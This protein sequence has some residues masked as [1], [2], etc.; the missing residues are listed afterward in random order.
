MTTPASSDSNQHLDEVITAYLKAVESGPAPDQQAWLA[1]YPELASELAAFFAAQ[2]Q[3]EQLAMPLRPDEAATLAPSGT[4]ASPLLGKVR[5]FGD[6]ELLEEIAR[7]GMGVVYKAR[8]VSLNRIVALKM[9]LA[10]QFAS[11][12]DVERFHRE[13]EAAAN[14]DHPNIVP[15]YEVGEHD[16]QHYF[17]MKLIEGGSLASRPLPMP[18]REAAE[19][20]AT[21]ARAVHHAHQRGILHRDLKPGNILI[22]LDDQPYVTD[23]GLAKRVEGEPRHTRTGSIVGTPSYMAPEQAR[24]EKVL[25]TAV[26]VYS[27]GAVFY[28]LLT[29]RPPFR[30]ETPLDTVLQVLDREPERPR[31]LNARIDADLET[32]CLKCLEK[33]SGKRY[34]SAEALAEE[35][36]RWLRGEPILARPVG[37]GERVWRWCRR[38]RGLAA[39]VTGFVLALVGGTVV[40]SLLAIAAQ[41]NAREAKD[42]AGRADREAANALEKEQE[43][44]ENARIAV[45]E[46]NEAALQRDEAR[47]N[48]YVLGINL[49][50]RAWDE[51]PVERARQLL[52]ELSTGSSGNELRG[53]EWNYLSRLTRSCKTLAGHSNDVLDVS[54]NPDGARLATAGAD[55]VIKTWST[56]SGKEVFSFPPQ[57]TA[58]WKVAFSSDGRHLL[59]VTTAADAT[60]G[61]VKA[62][63]VATGA[64]L[65]AAKSPTWEVA[66]SPEGEHFASATVDGVTVWNLST[67]KEFRSHKRPPVDAATRVTFS[68][69]GQLLAFSGSDQ[70]LNVWDLATD[71]ILFTL[72]AAGDWRACLAFSP[73]GR[74]LAC[75]KARQVTIWAAASGREVCSIPGYPDR[76]D[77]LALSPDG[78][79]ILSGCHDGSIHVND[80][81]SGKPL[82]SLK[83]HS[84]CITGV[85]WSKDGRNI[86]SSSGDWTTN[87]WNVADCQS[88]VSFKG[89]TRTVR[90][91][92]FS[93]DGKRLAS[94]SQDGSVRIWDTATGKTQLA[95]KTGPANSVAFS[96]NGQRLAFADSSGAVKVCE[97]GKGKELFSKTF[98]EQVLNVALSPDGQRLAFCTF[99]AKVDVWNIATGER[100][101][102]M[103]DPLQD[104]RFI[105]FGPDGDRL[106]I[107][108]ING[109]VQAW[110]LSTNK[111]LRGHGKLSTQVTSETS[112]SL[113]SAFAFGPGTE[114]FVTGGVDGGIKFRLADSGS[115][116]NAHRGHSRVVSGLAFNSD[117]HR[118]VSSSFDRTVKLWSLP[119][120]KELLTLKGPEKP[121]LSVAYSR[122]GQCIAAGDDEGAITVWFASH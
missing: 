90:S 2:K 56:K 76:V 49:A 91:L 111:V 30:A 74:L 33:E 60:G 106:F 100:L 107:G 86:A 95:L 5:Y 28:E 17:S 47:A 8:Q 12:E 54:F 40:A 81:E 72:K 42:N 80:T 11:P 71:K 13:A 82:F 108:E 39:A 7:G 59:S 93:P 113:T 84:Q 21:V 73:N 64:E 46:K 20:L 104:A 88:H 97:S 34:G 68:P 112:N 26:D 70:S 120:G 18:G 1:R 92:A 19:L 36:E 24:S 115:V 16:G 35:H 3:V 89:H 53:F 87:V 105:E 9:I 48:A 38:N 43:A 77:C 29:G 78:Q 32:I 57:A 62:W 118:L 50:Q 83:G 67:G 69:N 44:R 15:I 114:R 10:G 23:F 122:D 96:G 61:V 27:L 66:F 102:S 94:G 55:G 99:S 98:S 75:G 37:N 116:V 121:I 103:Q 25:T 63:D 65:C 4:P 101:F 58:A 22:G 85:A 119:A 14:L 117:G 52:K 110:E 109:A 41:A 31:K 79:R 6:Y 51:G 45:V